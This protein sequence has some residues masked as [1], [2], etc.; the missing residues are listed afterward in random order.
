M[1]HYHRRQLLLL[2]PLLLWRLLLLP[3]AHAF[4]VHFSGH[5]SCEAT[6]ELDLQKLPLLSASVPLLVVLLLMMVP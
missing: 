6:H 4:P 2:L 1:E 3:L 5:A